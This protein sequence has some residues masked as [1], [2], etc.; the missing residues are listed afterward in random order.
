LIRRF[1]PRGARSFSK[2]FQGSGGALSLAALCAVACVDSS[3]TTD[4]SSASSDAGSM[5]N[6]GDDDSGGS[7]GNA[8]PSPGPRPAPAARPTPPGSATDAGR[9]GS[10]GTNEPAAPAEPAPG[11]GPPSAVPDES[12]IDPPAGPVSDFIVVDQFGYR[13]QSEKIAVVRDPQIGVDADDSFTPGS[14]YQVIDAESGATAFEGSAEAWGNGA[15]DDASG[16]KAW[17]F[18]FSDLET[19]GVYYVLDTDND[20]R[21]DTFRVA[22]DVYREVLKQAVRTFF[23]QRAGFAKKA[24]FAEPDWVDAA[25]HVGPGQDTEAR[26]YDAPDDASTERDL[27]GGWFDAGDYNKYTPWTADYVV[28]MLRAYTERPEAFGDDYDLPDSGNG[29]ADIVDEARFGLEYLARLQQADGGVLSIVSLD[30]ASPPSAATGASLYGPAT[31]NASMRTAAAFAWGARVFADIDDASAQDLLDR[32]RSAYDWARANPTATFRNNEGAAAG[33]GAGQQELPDDAWQRDA[34]ALGAALALYQATG[35]S[36]YRDTFEQNYRVDGFSLFSGWLSG[37]DLNFT[38]MYLDYA[39][40]PDADPTIRDAIVTPFNDTLGSNDN[41]G[42]LS[43][44]PDPYLAQQAD[45]VWGSNAQKARIGS[46]FYL[47]EVHPDLDA[48]RQGD[49]V[50]AAERYVHYIH[51]VNPLGIVYLSAMNRFGAA[52]SVTQFYHTWF[53]DGTPW[54]TNPAPGFLTG[55]P[56]ASYDWDGQCPGNG[57]CPAA[58]PSPP[59]GQP[60]LKSYLD[61]NDNWPLDSWQVTENSD[62]Y[63]VEYIRLLSKFVE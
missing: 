42:M 12:S 46:L 57:A 26:R 35:E 31:A 21:S 32:A 5:A 3:S 53:G 62:G 38:D 61:F 44:N 34:Y 41:L 8:S 18:D 48:S 55:G 2:L 52:R 50:R 51:G 15:T 1:S 25:S 22:S 54:D 7:G 11:L 16:D 23:Y 9:G 6:N 30:G 24:P 47:Y 40:L 59:E 14:T 63:Q 17:W 33:I 60:P 10:G 43:T 13:P 4:G 45:Y 19:P 29:V 27:S 36:S 37:W 20:A 39:S 28:S 56:N 58:A 49:A